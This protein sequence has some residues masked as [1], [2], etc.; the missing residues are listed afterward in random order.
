[1]KLLIFKILIIVESDGDGFHAY[2]PE[3]KGIHVCGDTSEEALSVAKDAVEVYLKMSLAH[4]DPIPLGTLRSFSMKDGLLALWEKFS[5]RSRNRQEFLED[6]EFA[7][8]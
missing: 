6:V 2:C 3:L 7:P 4:G 1:M 8:V 5:L